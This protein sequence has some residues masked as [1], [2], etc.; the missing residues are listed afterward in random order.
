[1]AYQEQKGA[2]LQ[3]P[4]PFCVLKLNYVEFLKM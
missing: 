2:Y 3:Y 4:S 1:M